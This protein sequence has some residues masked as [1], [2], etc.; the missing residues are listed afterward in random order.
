MV[1]MM[2]LL[3]LA[4]SITLMFTFGTKAQ[5]PGCG[6]IDC[7]SYQQCEEYT[8][9]KLSLQDWCNTGNWSIFGLWPDYSA[10]CWPEYCHSPQWKDVTG[11]LLQEMLTFWNYCDASI[12][13]QQRSWGNEWN[14]HGTCM[15]YYNS[16]M[17][18]NDY[19]ETGLEVYKQRLS[20]GSIEKQC[21]PA[22]PH[23]ACRTLCMDLNFNVIHCA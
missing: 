19:F 20:D 18:Q 10:T 5:S 15:M 2:S 12:S 14:W 13:E 4:V 9:Y 16:S 3:S 11:E 1:T 22:R 7:P 23:G 17:V 21:G 8:S 6:G